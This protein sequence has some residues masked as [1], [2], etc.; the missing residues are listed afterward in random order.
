[1]NFNIFL[2]LKLWSDDDIKMMK[3]KLFGINAVIKHI[4][5]TIQCCCFLFLF[6]LNAL[7]NKRGGTNKTSVIFKVGLEFWLLLFCV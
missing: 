4:G 2:F 6:P 3:M 7:A 1:M 5:L